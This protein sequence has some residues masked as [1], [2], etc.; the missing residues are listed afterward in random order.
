MITALGQS[1]G[2]SQFSIHDGPS[3]ALLYETGS[4]RVYVVNERRLAARVPYQQVQ[5]TPVVGAVDND[6]SQYLLDAVCPGLPLRI[7]IGN[8]AKKLV[9]PLVFQKA[10]PLQTQ[11]VERR[12]NIRQMQFRPDRNRRGIAMQSVKPELLGAHNVR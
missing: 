7:V 10:I 2:K 3:A 12:R 6:V 8:G 9:G 5:L 1:A 11:F 4:D